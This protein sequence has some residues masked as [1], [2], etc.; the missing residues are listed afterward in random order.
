[1]KMK[2]HVVEILYFTPK[3]SKYKNKV[4][5]ISI[6]NDDGGV[7]SIADGKNRVSLVNCGWF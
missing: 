7:A 6:S 1:M 3:K 4:Y 2:H 5:E